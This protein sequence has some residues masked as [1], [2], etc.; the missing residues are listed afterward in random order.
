M[1]SLSHSL[2]HQLTN[3]HPPHHQNGTT[4]HSTTLEKREGEE[5]A[6]LNNML[7]KSNARVEELLATNNQWAEEAEERASEVTVLQIQLQ[8]AQ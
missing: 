7:R 3:G 4:E 1:L 8:D 2:S 5:M 6:R